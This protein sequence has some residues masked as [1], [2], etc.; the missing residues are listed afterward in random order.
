MAGEG[1]WG[2]WAL[3]AGSAAL[4]LM[5]LLVVIGLIVPNAPKEQLGGVDVETVKTAC[6]VVTGE[7]ARLC[8][9]MLRVEAAIE[10]GRC[11]LAH[12]Q[13]GPLLELS[14]E[15]LQGQL[16]TYTEALLTARCAGSG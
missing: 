13:A 12:N 8:Q 7:D 3:A 5:V 9:R 1:G 15:G 4:V 6:K 10:E 2:R 16:R 14:D 11:E